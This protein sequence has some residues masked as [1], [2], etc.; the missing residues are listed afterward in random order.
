V[1]LIVLIIKLII[2]GF[3][4]P[5][6]RVPAANP[7]DVVRQIQARIEAARVQDPR[8][9]RAA[10]P[11]QKMAQVPSSGR[12]QP[13]PFKQQKTKRKAPRAFPPAVIT[14]PAAKIAAAKPVAPPLAPPK[15]KPAVLYVDAKVLNRW[16]R[17]QTLRSQFILT[18]IFQPPISL[19]Q[20]HLL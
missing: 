17:P 11:R 20:S 19:R 8:A 12:K 7:N 1:E 10:P 2:R 5:Q 13:P 3:S 9:Q 15:P 14:A 6:T 16:L 4:S 18:E